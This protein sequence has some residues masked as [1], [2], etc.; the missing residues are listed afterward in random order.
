MKML[1]FISL[2][3]SK[4]MIII[5]IFYNKASKWKLSSLSIIP[6]SDMPTIIWTDLDQSRIPNLYLEVVLFLH[7]F[8]CSLIHP[9]HLSYLSI[10]LFNYL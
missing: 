8:P 4:D 2:Y 9:L 6:A 5:I 10:Y 1:Y 3:T 7:T